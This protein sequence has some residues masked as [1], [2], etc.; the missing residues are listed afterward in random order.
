MERER[1][2]RGDGY[3]E[4][5][6]SMEYIHTHPLTGAT[7]CVKVSWVRIPI[8]QMQKLRSRIVGTANQNSGLLPP[9]GPH[10]AA[11][12]S[13]SPQKRWGPD[14]PHTHTHKKGCQGLGGRHRW[15]ILGRCLHILE[16]LFV[17]F[18]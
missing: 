16:S 13:S 1:L 7:T 8:V 10:T 4:D 18:N 17:I 3:D 11:L 9:P 12:V 5:E 6:D 14:C 15:G 2:K